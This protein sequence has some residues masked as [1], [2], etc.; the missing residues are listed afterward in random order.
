MAGSCLLYTSALYKDSK[1]RKIS[2]G[3]ERINV[4]DIKVKALTPDI[5][6]WKWVADG[7]VEIPENDTKVVTPSF[8]HSIHSEICLV[9]TDTGHIRDERPEALA[10]KI[11]YIQAGEN[12]LFADQQYGKKA[13]TGILHIY[14]RDTVFIPVSYT[15]LSDR[16][17]CGNA[18]T[19][20]VYHR[21]S[22]RLE[23]F[24]GYSLPESVSCAERS[25][26][27]R[28]FR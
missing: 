17:L 11:V 12:L 24:I 25:D 19:A 16:K 23:N 8:L 20:C 26:P 13:E 15:H 27:E 28:T 3:G 10:E 4:L 14:F 6:F 21:A 2:D 18:G 9:K 22:G 1:I 7:Q 5:L